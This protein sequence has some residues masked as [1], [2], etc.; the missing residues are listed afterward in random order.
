MA[1]F[2]R[3]FI[4]GS[5]LIQIGLDPVTVPIHAGKLTHRLGAAGLGIGHKLLQR[6]QRHGGSLFDSRFSGR[7]LFLR[8][9][10]RGLPGGRPAG[11]KTKHHQH[12]EQQRA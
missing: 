7:F 6:A 10:C 3:F 11:A 12:G 1:C 5:R 4:P 2:P 9:R 8:F